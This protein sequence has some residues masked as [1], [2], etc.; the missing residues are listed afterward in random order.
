MH[1]TIVAAVFTIANFAAAS[2]MADGLSVAAGRSVAVDAVS[3]GHPACAACHLP[4][5]AGRPEVGIPRL[6]GL[7]ATYI[8]AQLEYFAT[9]A[10]H[11][12]VMSP[13]AALLTTDQRRAVAD[14]F[15]SLPVPPDADTLPASSDTLTRGRD[16]FL[17]GDAASGAPACAN[18]HG[19]TG[20]GVGD[21]SPRLA[22]QSAA[23][24]A[25]TLNA[26][27]TGD[28]RDPKGAFMQAEARRLSPSSITA[29]AAYVAALDDDR[30]KKP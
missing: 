13:F 27:R 29:V 21:F 16:L 9:G 10:R 15:S 1:C 7:G 30:S 22:G 8:S 2:A 3:P 26:W 24:V 5:G 6:A 20:L 19:S 25:E 11:S 23:Y 17:N 18:C 4:D 12:V 28:L 14:Y